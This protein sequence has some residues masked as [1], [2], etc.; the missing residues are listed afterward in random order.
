MEQAEDRRGVVCVCGGGGA[1]GLWMRRF[2]CHAHCECF[3][4]TPTQ[5]ANGA[6]MSRISAA[7]AI[8]ATAGASKA[9]P[10]L[11][12]SLPTAGQLDGQTGEK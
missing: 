2:C 12:V 3:V 4:L 9:A 6:D 8:T 5:R 7:S 1:R 11:E 10:D